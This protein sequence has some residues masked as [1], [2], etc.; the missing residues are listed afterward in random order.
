MHLGN[1]SFLPRSLVDGRPAM[2]V[3]LD[4]R[5]LNYGDG[6]F[7]TIAVADSVPLLWA[8]HM[9]RLAEG[10]TR[11]G[12]RPPSE[13]V[14]EAEARTVCKGLAR[15][16]LKII[17]TRGKGGQGYA[18]LANDRV[19]RIVRCLPAPEYPAVLSRE[20]VRARICRWRLARDRQLAGIKHLNRLPQVMARA[21]WNDEYE[22]GLMLDDTGIVIEGTRS[23]LFVVTDK[24][25][26][27]PDLTL[28]GV[29]GVARELVLERAPAIGVPVN[30]EPL[31]LDGVRAADEIFLTNSL[32]GIWPVRQLEGKTYAIGPVTQAIQKAVVDAFP[33]LGDI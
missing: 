26:R 12:I 30:V 6:L 16:V 29:W 24:H 32:I 7:E 18:P 11:L 14:L 33:V 17:V 23:N 5:G 19:C 4:D 10:A 15:A 31:S 22:E 8:A 21:E 13:S 28:A 3:D 25:L 2:A 1:T 27:T 9:R 20:G